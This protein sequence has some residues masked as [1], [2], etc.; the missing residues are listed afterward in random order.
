[1]NLVRLPRQPVGPMTHEVVMSFSQHDGIRLI[2][3]LHQR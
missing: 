2:D 3:S 1:M